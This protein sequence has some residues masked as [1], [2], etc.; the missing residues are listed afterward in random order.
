M[1]VQVIDA[2]AKG[3]SW[4]QRNWQPIAMLTFL[5]LVICD[6]FRL[7]AFRLSKEA[8]CYDK[9]LEVVDKIVDS[10]IATLNGEGVKG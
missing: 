4:V 6:S 3:E 10:I 1:E 5:V 9:A 8:A 7:L 2:E